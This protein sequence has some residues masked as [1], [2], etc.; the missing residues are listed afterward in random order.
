MKLPILLIFVAIAVLVYSK[1]RASRI[2]YKEKK[3]SLDPTKEYEF[4]WLASFDTKAS[5]EACADEVKKHVDLVTQ[6]SNSPLEQKW[7][8]QCSIV[9]KANTDLVS[10]YESTIRYCFSAK[11]GEFVHATVTTPI[12]PD[13]TIG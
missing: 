3:V 4:A 8:L 12:S 2:H 11:G 13:I 10:Q 1:M 5:S 9:C 6:I 7:M